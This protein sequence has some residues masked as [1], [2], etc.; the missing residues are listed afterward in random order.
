MP[1]NSFQISSKYPMDK[2]VFLREITVSLDSTGM[3]KQVIA[4]GLGDTVFCNAVISFDNWQTTYQ[5]GTSRMAR[6][7]YSEQFNVYS[8]AQNVT[9]D[10]YFY[11]KANQTAKIRIW[12][13]FN[14]TSTATAPATRNQSANK[15]V[16]N[17]K[18]NYFK[19][20]KDG[21]ADVS[22][23]DVAV[24]HNLGYK[25][26]VELW[27]DFEYDDNGWTYYNRPDCFDANDSYGQAVKVT[28]SQLILR[29]GGYIFKVKRFY[30]RI[31]VDASE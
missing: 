18:Y 15:F 19:L 6:Q 31:Y 16:L 9:L 10:V 24:P 23:G 28:A 1:A 25:P 26:I 29:N 3:S 22:G 13:V 2:V 7:Y 17:S 30:Y 11:E 21:I 27:A 20:L 12:G 5:A 14:S 4:H 8:D